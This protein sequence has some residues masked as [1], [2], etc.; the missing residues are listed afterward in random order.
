MS[1]EAPQDITKKRVVYQIPG[2]D[3]V[4]IRRDVEYR[5]T[6][7]GVLTMDVYYPP[8]W[9]SGARIPAVVFVSGYSDVGFQK[10]LGCKLKDMASYVSWGQLTAA[11]GLVAIAYSAVE[12]AAD[13]H[14]LLEYVRKNAAALGIDENRIGV[15]ACS[16]NVPNALSI[17]MGE[18]RDYLKCAV[19]CYGIM[20]DLDGS[21]DVAESARQ[22][23]FANPSAGN[24]VNELPKD[25]P[26]FIVRAGQDEMPHLNE[27]IDRFLAKALIHNLPVTFANHAEAPHAFDVMHDSETS[28]EII[29]Q[30]LAFVRFHLLA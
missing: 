4:T 12:P 7:T 24:S 25:L 14:A 19:L 16:G 26:L 13:I 9:K 28:R 11:S 6:D 10:M 1:E 29:R 3:A 27:T 30:I 22:W 18:G 23:G 5:T 8:D 17:L 20:L 21:T 15:W 2:M